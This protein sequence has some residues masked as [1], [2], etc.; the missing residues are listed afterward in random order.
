[1]IIR[2]LWLD[3]FG[4]FEDSHLLLKPGINVIRGNNEAGKSTIYGFIRCMLFGAERLRG[5]GAGKDDFTRF[6]PW[7]GSGRYSGRLTY[8]SAGRNYRIVRDFARN[9]LTFTLIDEDAGREIADGADDISRYITGMNSSNFRNSIGIGQMET[10]PDTHFAEDMQTYMANLSMGAN[11]AV[12]VS[13]AMDY[14]RV[15]RKRIAS[16]LPDE[17]IRDNDDKI[18]KIAVQMEEI[19]ELTRRQQVLND[20]AQALK[21]EEDALN[22]G[23]DEELKTDQAQRLEAARL[24]Q[25]NN[26]ITTRYREK[27]AKLHEIEQATAQE[28]QAKIDTVIQACEKR[29]HQIDAAEVRIGELQSELQSAPLKHLAII[30]PL[31]ALAVCVGLA[32][33]M[34][35]LDGGQR[36]VGAVIVGAAAICMLIVMMLFSSRK[37][38]R[39]ASLRA[40]VQTMG[41]AQERAFSYYN[42]SSIDGLRQAASVNGQ[43]QIEIR[44]IRQE[45]A[46][47]K[48]QYDAIQEPLKPYIE[49]Y[50]EVITTDSLA[51]EVT[52]SQ[53]AVLKKQRE[54]LLKQAEQIEWQLE[55]LIQQQAERT[56]LE[57]MNVSLEEERNKMNED[58]QAL[59]LCAQ[60]LRDI[61]QRIHGTFGEEM[62]AYVSSLLD[63]LT[64]GAHKRLVIDENFRILV[65]DGRELLLPQQLSGGTADQMWF[66]AR[67]AVSQLFFEEK[68][69]LI[70]D[71]SFV[72]YDDERLENTLRWLAEQE[73]FSQVI[74]L[75]CQHRESDILEKA[76][77]AYNLCE[78]AEQR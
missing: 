26:D 59:D 67:M 66:A 10:A 56:A 28:A 71:D 3:H 38:K 55:H 52:R 72:T 16:A 46:E 42:V 27:K 48:K 24:I 57:E 58:L 15:E 65:D 35:G 70:L 73:V 30:L 4:R 39:L 6:Q 53:A 44:R 76:G 78:L 62:N 60:T 61:T 75:S 5:R 18:R 77:I 8:Q 2:D 47:L 14:L 40:D 54:E 68:M 17:Q 11:E 9:N 29:S 12:D 33:N 50:G 25:Q 49:K 74:I 34:L 51:G 23:A 1:M 63:K 64:A 21:K 43:Q 13:K 7:E 31:L 36:A 20:Q 37:R 69:P 45:L 41:A 19:P 32:G 22:A